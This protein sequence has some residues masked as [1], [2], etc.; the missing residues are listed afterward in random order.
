MLHKVRAIHSINL[1]AFAR[2]ARKSRLYING[3]GS[4]I[5]DVNQQK[6]NLV[7]SLYNKNRKK[8]RSPVMMYGCGIGPVNY[9]GDRELAAKIISKLC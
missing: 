6:I 1:I 9:K 3:G 7:L 8:K 2:I 4:L 5:Q